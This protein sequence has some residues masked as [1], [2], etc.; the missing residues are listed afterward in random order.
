MKNILSKAILA[1]IGTLVVSGAAQAASYI[2]T[3]H[4]QTMTDQLANKIEAAGG[5]MTARLPQI[6]VVIVESDDPGF[7]ARAAGISGVRSAAADMTL[8]YAVPEPQY[9]I[10]EQFANPPNS[11]DDDRFFDLQWGHAAID[12]AGAW[13][14][15]YRGAGV[16]VEKL[17]VPAE[18]LELHFG[19]ALAAD[20]LIDFGLR[21]SATDRLVEVL[22]QETR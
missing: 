14:S 21:L 5:T 12:A 18:A 7:A 8:Q 4:A 15:G 17:H 19:P 20:D 10:S 11:G 9:E 3:S 1:A 22:A 13:N 6:G 16:R 2:V